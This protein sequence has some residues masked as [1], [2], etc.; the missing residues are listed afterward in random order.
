MPQEIASNTYG[1][2]AHPANTPLVYLIP[3][4]RS[5]FVW[6]KITNHVQFVVCRNP[7]I[8]SF[9]DF[10]LPEGCSS[11]KVNQILKF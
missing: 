5:N 6:L 8:H 7:K 10:F 4:T 9:H 1:S 11:L 2:P 3:E